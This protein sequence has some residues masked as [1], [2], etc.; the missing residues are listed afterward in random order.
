MSL[1]RLYFQKT[2]KGFIHV[3]TLFLCEIYPNNKVGRN[4]EFDF[5]KSFIIHP[6]YEVTQLNIFTTKTSLIN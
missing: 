1:N 4:D 2:Y 3:T 5:T 6:T